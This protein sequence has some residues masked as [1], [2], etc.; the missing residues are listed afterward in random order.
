MHVAAMPLHVDAGGNAALIMAA[1]PLRILAA[2]PL[3]TFI[4]FPL[5]PPWPFLG[6]P[7]LKKKAWLSAPGLKK[8]SKIIAAMPLH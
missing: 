3:Y 1:M 8:Q 2:M 4:R 5:G 6:A 7:D